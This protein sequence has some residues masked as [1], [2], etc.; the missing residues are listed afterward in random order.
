MENGMN[1]TRIRKKRH[2]RSLERLL[3]FAV[4]P[5]IAQRRPGRLLVIAPDPAAFGVLKGWSPLCLHSNGFA[6]GDPLRCELTQLPIQDDSIDVVL[7]HHQ[8]QSG[9]ERILQEA[10]RIL[11]AGGELFVLG[12]GALSWRARCGR[13]REL[14]R[15]KVLTTCQRLR[16]RAF[17]IERCAAHGVL[18]APVYGERRWQRWWLPPLADNV[19]IHGR[20]SV[21]R[22]IVRSI[23]FRRPKAMGVRSPAADSVFRETE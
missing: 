16:H 21:L 6:P 2:D 12:Q 5:E 23:R 7:L 13:G 10:W 11:V 1:S 22:P 15:L 8:L 17:A 20:H 14:P 9:Q 18:G 3:R 4:L 19:V